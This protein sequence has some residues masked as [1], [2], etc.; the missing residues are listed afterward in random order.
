MALLRRIYTLLLLPLLASVVTSCMEDFEPDIP[1]TP[2]LCMNAEIT[3]GDSIILFLTRSWRWS[4]DEDNDPDIDVENA[5]V[6]LI[7]NGEWRE[8]LVPSFVGNGYDTEHPFYDVSKCYRSTYI[9]VSGDVIRLEVTST[10]YGEAWAEV[11]V[12]YPVPID[13][14][15][16]QNLTCIPMTNTDGWPALKERTDF[17]IGCK[18]LVYFT[19]PAGE[20]NYYDFKAGLSPYSSYDDKA[21]ALAG[22]VSPLFI[23][24]P[25]FTEHVSVLESAVAETS[26][27]TI[28]SDRQIYGKTY[29]LRVRYDP[30]EFYYWNPSDMQG[31]KEYGIT[32][33][34]RHVDPA[35]YKHVLSVWEANDAI[36]GSLGGIGLANPV[37][38]Y[39]NVSTHAGVVAA[40]AVSQVTVS[41]VD[42]I[43]QSG[44]IQ[45]E[46]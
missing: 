18:L 39:S 38:A 43:D 22:S 19:D 26:G 37:Y 15:E 20:S 42:L 14:V 3:P 5:E 29:P 9:P 23:D 36:V 41:M 32:V 46:E 25:L 44:V 8:N 13:R 10:E 6:R 4:E 33:T 1:S 34:L 21:T 11:T 12:P 17:I 7:V 45:S 27:Y 31:P 40:Y 16:V 35:Y 24:E 2:V 30:F 28:F